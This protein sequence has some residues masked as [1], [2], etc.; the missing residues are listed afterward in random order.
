[1]KRILITGVSGYIGGKMAHALASHERVEALIGIDI[2]PPRN[3]PAELLFRQHDVRL[4]MEALF[5][6]HAVD[7]VIHAAY[8]LPPIHD[9]ALMEAVNVTGTRN[10]IAACRETGVE[11]LVYTSSAAAYGFHPDNAIPLSEDSPLR[12]NDDFTYS[13]NKKEIEFIFKERARDLD[14]TAVTILRPCF[15]VGPGFANPLASH[16]KKKVVLCP[17]PSA[18]M[19]FVHEDDLLRIVLLCLEKQVTGIFNVGGEGAMAIADMVRR[20][21]NVYCPLPAVVLAPLN[22]LAWT[23]RMTW[24][25]EFPGPALNLMRYSWIVSSAKLIRETGFAY[26]YGSRA[27]FDA[28]VHAVRSGIA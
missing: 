17:S 16:L 11:H 2:R 15:V 20:L 7:T 3:P 24:L 1:M 19:Q 18:P 26:Q 22:H 5:R 14:R 4:P 27:A 12:G 6:R 21:G 8:V 25:T 23:L 13:K 9:T 10:V 28:F